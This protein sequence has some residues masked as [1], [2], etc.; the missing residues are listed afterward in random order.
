MQPS[1]PSTSA[2]QTPT[3]DWSTHHWQNLRLAMPIV[4]SALAVIGI[5]TADIIAMGWIDSVNLAAG[6][7]GL[8]YYQP[9][10]FFALGITLPVGAL[11]AQA[12]GA[13]DDRQIRRALRQGLLIGFIIGIASAPIMLAGPTILVWLGQ[14][15]QLAAMTSEFLFWSAIGLPFNF[16]FFVL[17]QY[18]VAHQKPLPQVIASISGMLFNALGNY[19]LVDGVGPFP[20]MGLAGIA[21][22]TTLTWLLIS[23]ALAFYIATTEPYRSSQP[24]RRLWVMDWHVTWR[25]TRIGFPI[26]L[27]IVAESGMFIAIGLIIGIFGTAAL[28]ASAIANQIAAIAFMVPIALGQAGTIRVAHFAGAGDRENL[29]RSAL[30]VIIVGTVVTSI[31]MVIL[32]AAPFQL[33]DIYLNHDDLLLDEVVAL[34]MPMVLIAALFQ[35]PDGL[36]GIANSILRGMNDT[37]ITAVLAISSFWLVGVGGGTLIGVGLGYGPVGVWSGLLLGLV[38][39]SSTL[40]WRVIRALRHLRAGGNILSD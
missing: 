39:A 27:T 21:L 22:S 6:S 20:A 15:T 33:I 18:V 17:R 16:I 36:Q 40:M 23:I 10:Y 7:L 37:R 29:R 25:I 24:F 14:D 38:A 28:A 5:S 34:A 3:L 9:L 35:I 32:L 8:R 4:V 11:I 13:D 1:S 31:T 19:L 26:G 30:S 12:L 2:P